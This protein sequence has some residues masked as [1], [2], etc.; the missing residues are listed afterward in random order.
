M[1]ARYEFGIL[2]PLNVTRDGVPVPIRAERQR[3]L[4]AALLI[5]TDQVASVGALAGRLW[6][7]NPPPGARN[8]VQNYVLRLR[9]TLGP[10]VVVTD[11]HGYALNAAPDALD[12]RRFDSLVRQGRTLMSGGEHERA[13][14]VL[15]EA[16]GLWRGEALADLPAERY[17]DVVAALHERRLA[18]QELWIDSV[19]GCGRPT[20]ALAE[21]GR[22]TERHPLRERF[23]AQQMLA[24]F[25]SGRQGEALECYRQVTRLLADELGIDPGGELQALHRRMLAADP[26][27]AVVRPPTAGG[28]GNLPSETTSFIGREEELA[29]TRR[30]LGVSRLVTLTGVGGVGKTRLALRAA[31]KV[32]ASFPEGVWLADLAALADAT[33]V[34]RAVADALEIRDQSVRSTV[35]SMADHL[36][37]RRLLLVLDNCEHLVEAVAPLVQRLLCAAPSLRVLAT[38]R[39]RLAVPGEHVFL[40]SGLALHHGVDGG[41]CEA[42]RLLGDRAQ[43][44]AA[45]VRDSDS[46]F[47]LCRRLDG[48]PLA[49][50]LAA[51]RLASLTVEEI[52]DRLDDRFQLLAARRAPAANRSRQTLRGVM[53]WSYH[54]CTPAER[55]LWTR[56][57]IF[58]GGLDLKAAEAVC[59]G[60]GIDGADMLDLITGLVHKSVVAV[61]RD[62]RAARYRLL[63]TIR[64][65]GRDRLRARGDDTEYRVRHLDHYHALARSAAADWCGP[66]EVQWLDRLRAELPNL[67]AALGFCLTRTDR[68]ASGAEIA[69]DLTRARS[70]FFSSTLG[71]ARHWLESLAA[72]LGPEVCETT[73]TVTAMKA[74]IATFQGDQETAGA[75]LEELRSAG[76]SW[77]QAPSVAYVEGVHAFLAHGDPACIDLLARAREGFRVAGHT[78]DAHMATM[79]WA[80]AAAFLGHQSIAVSAR[81]AYVADAKASGAEWACTWAQWCTGLTELLHGDPGSA[82]SPLSDALVRQRAMDDRWGPAWALETLAWTASALAHHHHAV[83]LL[84]AAHRQRQLTGA[85]LAG[86]KPLHLHHTRAKNRVRQHLQ[87]Q[88]FTEAWQ[89]GA[90]AEDSVALALGI[91]DELL[92]HATTNTTPR[93]DCGPA[94]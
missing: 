52:L 3:C 74:F 72:R 43:A 32:S 75:F 15:G 81:D 29:E 20:D 31:R 50:E 12:A 82:I 28:S 55:L 2:G 34:A 83:Q 68:A 21:L 45:P 37:D 16:L 59:V 79:F 89:S 57:S 53:E 41:A 38:S 87:A 39:E 71:E 56:L 76:P 90:N 49:I 63:E 30:L 18:A 86:L 4:L 10:D 24:L 93:C 67:R 84:G 9:R 94:M 27:I 36:R 51:G 92:R 70:W 85:A 66:R 17:R 88:A 46:A 78:G 22:L 7:E 65:Y 26:Q 25:H 14:A 47:E 42:V 54:L 19:I 44:C 48:I 80:L 69:V 58:A 61:D 62:G 11:R 64:Q 73:I 5:E 33:L 35:D 60:D 77:S 91:A 13:A 6:G 23:W 8:A 40:V 1:D